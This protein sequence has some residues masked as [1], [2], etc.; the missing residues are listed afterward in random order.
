MRNTTISPFVQQ[1]MHAINQQV[2]K[3]RAIKGTNRFTNY[4]AYMKSGAPR[5]TWRQFKNL[6]Q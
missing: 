5:E 6:S 4:H 2:M 1:S 3:T